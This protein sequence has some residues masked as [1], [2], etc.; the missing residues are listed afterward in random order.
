MEVS[1]EDAKTWAENGNSKRKGEVK[2]SAKADNSEYSAEGGFKQGKRFHEI[3]GLYVQNLAMV[4]LN[5]KNNFL[6]RLLKTG[7]TK[8]GTCSEHATG[9]NKIWLHSCHSTLKIYRKRKEWRIF[10]FNKQA[11]FKTSESLCHIM[12]SVPLA[13]HP[14]H[15]D[16]K[17]NSPFNYTTVSLWCCKNETGEECIL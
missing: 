13:Y 8:T 6:G 17:S 5:F 11:L 16:V 3:D 9:T 14:Y 1:R 10:F 4:F 12:F 7:I 2:F 15:T